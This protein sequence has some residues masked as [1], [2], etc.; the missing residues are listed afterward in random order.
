[1]VFPTAFTTSGSISIITNVVY[2]SGDTGYTTLVSGS[3]STTGF[4]VHQN[5]MTGMSMDWF[6][7]GY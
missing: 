3:V 6:A 7:V 2:A 5:N 4:T 1:V